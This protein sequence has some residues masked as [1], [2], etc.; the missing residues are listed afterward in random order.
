MSGPEVATVVSVSKPMVALHKEQFG[1]GRRLV[2]TTF[3]GPNVISPLLEDALL[4]AERTTVAMGECLRVEESRLFLQRRRASASSRRWSR[5]SCA[6]CARFR[7][8][9]MRATGS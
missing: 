5:S 9:V 1:R 8:R 2:R 7:V 6:R 3:A 4:P